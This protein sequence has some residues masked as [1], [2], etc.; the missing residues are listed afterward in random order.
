MLVHHFMGQKHC[1]RFQN[2]QFKL[3]KKA[4]KIKLIFIF[5]FET[6]WRLYHLS[7][8]SSVVY[9]PQTA[10][11][12]VTSSCSFRKLSI[13]NFSRKEM[14][15]KR[16]KAAEG[17]AYSHSSHSNSLTLSIKMH[18]LLKD[19]NRALTSVVTVLS[20]PAD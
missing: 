8:L 16:E 6:E 1:L 3:K 2:L 9:C 14:R 13:D 17:R 10:Q 11:T 5:H 4:I 19:P 20:S 18:D 7:C 15:K 12:F